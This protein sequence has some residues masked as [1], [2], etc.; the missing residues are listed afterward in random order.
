MKKLLLL[1]I[2]FMTATAAQA[3]RQDRVKIS[4]K[5]ID[6]DS[7][8]I[9]YA[10]VIIQSATDSTQNWGVISNESGEFSVQVPVGDHR[11]QVSFVG[12]KSHRAQLTVKEAMT[13]QPI[14][15][16]VEAT[17]IGDVV[18]T[19][20]AITRRAGGYVVNMEGTAV[21]KGR[22]LYE[23]LAFAPGMMIMDGLK[24]NGKGVSQ[25]YINNRLLNFSGTDLENYLRN[26]A[27]E[28]I[29]SIE[30]I[31]IAGSEYD[32]SA[33]GGILKITLRRQ[34]DGGYFGSVNLAGSLNYKWLKQGT[35]S[36]NIS[37]RKNR[38]SLYSNLSYANY[39][40]YES[41]DETTNFFTNQ[42]TI[43]SKSN[44]HMR[45]NS[46]SAEVNAVYELTDNQSLGAVVS[47][48]TTENDITNTSKTELK[49]VSE[50]IRSSLSS[51]EQDMT[52]LLSA[53]LDYNLNIGKKG[54]TFKAIADYTSN[55]S[56]TD[57]E[58]RSIYENPLTPDR[59]YTTSLRGPGSIANVNFDF[60][61][62]FN[63]IY[64]MKTGAKLYNMTISNDVLYMNDFD[65]LWVRDEAMSED[66]SYSETVAAVYADLSA[67]YGKVM[68]SIGIRGENSWIDINSDKPGGD[69]RKNYFNAFPSLNVFYN[70]NQEKGHS[71]SL[72]ANMKITRPSY[73]QLRPYT[74]PLSEYSLI[75][76]N[77]NL[78]PTKITN[79]SLTG[80]IFQKYS[81]TVDASYS[82]DPTAQVSM[83]SEND[84]NVLIY[85]FTNMDNRLD[86]TAV[87]SLPITVTRWWNS[88]WMLAGI[89]RSETYINSLND[90][91]TFRKT[92]GMA[93]MNN[94]FTLPAGFQ[95]D[96]SGSYMTPV[97]QG[98][99]QIG[100]LYQLDAGITKSL[101]KDRVSVS[102]AYKGLFRPNQN[103]TVTDPSYNKINIG[104]NDQKYFRLSLRYNFKGGQKV[105]VKKA[106]SGNASESGRL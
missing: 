88:T 54:T 44:I 53:S 30:V 36:A 85:K 82:V 52:S 62:P 76:G 102:L 79:V 65:G 20:N 64:S 18:I 67:N 84:P 41:Y 11:I 75:V 74:H 14:T 77:P 105:N 98:N 16:A 68:A 8:P 91:T 1:L 70:M 106:N 42:S 40:N 69:L 96:L 55:F 100:Q 23:A 13:L 46:V 35:A 89:N 94:I 32:A 2:V 49:S 51:P 103:I 99:M 59:H 17:A 104:T 43:Q 73:S 19:A 9:E 86:L 92:T 63:K 7:K 6:T 72:N 38:L 57:T 61:I 87:L 27:A 71:L 37:Y 3:A 24:I 26:L 97:I 12:Y 34:K 58:F 4:G 45:M 83:P 25:V 47:Y 29:K 31:P 80:T 95:I 66:F 56:D 78:N 22:N 101:F 93:S 33:T 81:L 21:A 50:L 10:T 90:L 28:D 39:K 15:L 48:M 60:S 5:I